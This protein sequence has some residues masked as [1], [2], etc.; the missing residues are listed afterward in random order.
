MLWSSGLVVVGFNKPEE[1]KADLQLPEV[2][3]PELPEEEVP[4][5]NMNFAWPFSLST[6]H[7]PAP[8]E[9][10]VDLKMPDLSIPSATM[11]VP[12]V[13]V[14]QPEQPDVPSA[15]ISIWPF[16]GVAAPSA[17]VVDMPHVDVPSMNNGKPIIDIKAPN[18]TLGGLPSMAM[19]EAPKGPEASLP[20]MTLWPFSGPTAPA[21]GADGSVIKMPNLPAGPTV[22]GEIPHFKLPDLHQLQKPE[23]DAPAAPAATG[24]T[25][26]WP[27]STPRTPTVSA[28]TPTP[29]LH[30]PVVSVPTVV[31]PGG[32][33]ADHPNYIPP[34]IAVISPH[35]LE[36]P[37][38]DVDDSFGLGAVG[39]GLGTVGN[40]LG[41]G[42]GT[43]GNAIGNVWPFSGASS[44]V[45]KPTMSTPA[46]P[47]APGLHADPLAASTPVWSTWGDNHHKEEPSKTPPASLHI[48]PGAY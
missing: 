39:N 37:K 15:S 3:V 46:T 23:I 18:V 27:F 4:G 25:G 21:V 1:P 6:P 31:S 10:K 44:P 40:G 38:A 11:A 29:S 32:P 16:S 45:D 13:N 19:P 24:I 48:P 30:L 5:V 14:K 35:G 26:I 7:A 9:P 22:N 47:T 42:L 12:N 36:L 33:S 2:D 34:K 20:T 43:V 17:P 28:T 8:V 41:N